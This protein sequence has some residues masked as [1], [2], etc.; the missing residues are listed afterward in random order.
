MFWAI[1]NQL[2]SS[3]ASRRRELGIVGGVRAWFD[4]RAKAGWLL[5]CRCRLFTRYQMQLPFNKAVIE[6]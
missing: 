2:G 5:E 6:R 1:K 4:G 3:S